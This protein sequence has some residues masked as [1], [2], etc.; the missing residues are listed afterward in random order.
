MA[1]GVSTRTVRLNYG[2]SFD[3]PSIA[4][5]LAGRLKP[6]VLADTAKSV[7]FFMYYQKE[8]FHPP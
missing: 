7:V 3:T 5:S 8:K 2:Q 6:R 4:L 1:R